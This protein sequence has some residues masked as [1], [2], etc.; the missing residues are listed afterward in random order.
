M[1]A[2]LGPLREW[3]TVERV[4]ALDREETKAVV[5]RREA[6]LSD[7]LIPGRTVS[8][9]WAT[10]ACFLSHFRAIRR[11]SGAVAPVVVFEDDAALVNGTDHVVRCFRDAFQNA[12]DDWE[13]LM[14]GW[15]KPHLHYKAD[16][17][18]P[19]ARYFRVPKTRF[20]TGP[21]PIIS[22]ALGAYAYAIH[23]RAL[24]RVIARLEELERGDEKW[25]KGIIDID[26]AIL[27]EGWTV[28]AV[29]PIC[30][31]HNLT[32]ASTR[33]K[34]GGE[35]TPDFNPPEKRP[36]APCVQQD[37]K[38]CCRVSD[39]RNPFKGQLCVPSKPGPKFSSGHVCEPYVWACVKD[40]NDEVKDTCVKDGRQG[41]SKCA[42]A[43][44]KQQCC[45]SYDM[46]G[47]YRGQDCVPAKP[48]SKFRSGKTCEPSSS[49]PAEDAAE[50]DVADPIEL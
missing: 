11:G 10:G 13:V 37:R 45:A 19:D 47:Q 41:L 28:Y 30:F 1:E 21:D 35:N 12:P 7:A 3:Y 8:T 20:D 31:Y 48:G 43:A 6:V 16:P 27:V 4:P 34:K 25:P 9:Y 40:L 5:K 44:T 32:A 36:R 2:G 14:L 42:D 24:P 23:E 46:R 50:C 15:W 17:V 29:Q 26:V 38:S 18:D 22:P 49:V 33:H 39:S